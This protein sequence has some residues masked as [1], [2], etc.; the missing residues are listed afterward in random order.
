MNR[1]K[2]IITF[3]SNLAFVNSNAQ[4]NSM[5][6][7]GDTSLP[8]TQEELAKITALDKGHYKYT[9][10]DFFAKPKQSSLSFR[11]TESIFPIWKKIILGNAMFM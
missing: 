9:V 4:N 6:L 3:L 2:I 10:E 1:I 5:S 7:P 8:S 11:Q